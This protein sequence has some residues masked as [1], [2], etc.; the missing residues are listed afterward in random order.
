[1]FNGAHFLLY[2]KDPEADRAFFLKIAARA[3]TAV[4]QPSSAWDAKEFRLANP[5][6]A[7]GYGHAA[8]WTGA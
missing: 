5:G 3:T 1:M 7:P 4:K 2:S 8:P 6:F